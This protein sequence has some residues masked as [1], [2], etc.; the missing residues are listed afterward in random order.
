MAFRLAQ[1]RSR[2]YSISWDAEANQLRIHHTARVWAQSA[3]VLMPARIRPLYVR[4]VQMFRDADV[5]TRPPMQ[6]DRD[7]FNVTNRMRNTGAVSVTSPDAIGNPVAKSRMSGTGC[8]CPAGEIRHCPERRPLRGPDL[9][10]AKSVNAVVRHYNFALPRLA[11][12]R[13]AEKV[14]R[15][16]VAGSR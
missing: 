15:S 5:F 3:Q 4:F 2:G 16:H 10:L 14:K 1:R 12:L 8:R 6:A 7:S 9:P 13:R 11:V